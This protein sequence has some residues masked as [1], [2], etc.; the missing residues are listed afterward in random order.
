MHHIY[1]SGLDTT[2]AAV[3]R[4]SN[5]IIHPQYE[6]NTDYND[7]AMVRTTNP[8]TFNEGV[9]AVCLPFRLKSRILFQYKNKNIQKHSF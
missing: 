4:L 8:M 9:S 6:S 5:I 3:Y 7:I 2:Y 1:C